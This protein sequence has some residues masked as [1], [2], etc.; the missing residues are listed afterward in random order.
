MTEEFDYPLKGKL[1]S[2]FFIKSTGEPYVLTGKCVDV[3]DDFLVLET[4]DGVDFIVLSSIDYIH[5]NSKLK[6]KTVTKPEGL[7]Q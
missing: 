6:P 7:Y 5:S 1:V 4:K 3:T 2:V